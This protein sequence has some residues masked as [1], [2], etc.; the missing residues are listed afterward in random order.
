MSAIALIS[1]R[2]QG[3]P[4]TRPTKTGGQ[5]TFFT[6]RVANGAALEFWNVATFSDAVRDELAGLAEG[7]ALSCSGLFHAERYEWNGETRV[8]LKLTAD[9]VLVLKARSRAPKTARDKSG[10]GA[11]PIG[12]A[13][14][15]SSWAHPR[16]SS[17]DDDP[18]F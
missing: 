7:A 5:V 3:E 18:P 16:G 6:L 17:L 2:L 15:E 12:R 1:G 14:A 9:T 11:A 4:A 8:R 10:G 13:A